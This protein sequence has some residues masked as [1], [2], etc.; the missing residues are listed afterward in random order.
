MG[1]REYEK[2]QAANGDPP[3]HQFAKEVSCML[4]FVAAK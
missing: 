4:V 2:H 3:H 1:M